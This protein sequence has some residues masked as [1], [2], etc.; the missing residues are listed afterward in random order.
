MIPYQLSSPVCG[1]YPT[2]YV[3]DAEMRD[4]FL[5][6]PGGLPEAPL[7]NWV[8][9]NYGST[10]GLLL[11]IGSHVGDWAIPF[12]VAGS[13]VVACEPNPALTSC[14]LDAVDANGISHFTTVGNAVSDYTGEAL[15]VG[16]SPDGGGAS[17]VLDFA[18]PAVWARVY[19]TT[20]DSMNLAPTIIKIDVE[21]AEV[22]VLRGAQF[23]IREHR[24]VIFFECWPDERGQ[25]REELFDMVADLGYVARPTWWQPYE[26]RGGIEMY[27]A[28]SFGA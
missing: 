1:V 19:T 21:G 22:D 17:I 25:R 9:E 16:A 14:I 12:A 13:Q 23:T 4:Y 11:D 24:P 18:A 3:L 7:I 15:L 10:D 26:G 2:L 5:S 27:I 28:E 20:I 6:C 8:W